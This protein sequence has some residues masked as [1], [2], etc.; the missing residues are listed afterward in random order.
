VGLK[1]VGIENPVINSP[2][3][4]P[5]RH[6]RFTDEGI[7]DQINEGRRVSSYFVPIPRPKKRSQ[8][9]SLETQWTENAPIVGELSYHTLDSLKT[10]RIQTVA[11]EVARVLLQKYFRDDAGQLK[12]FLFPQLVPIA[13]RWLDECLRCKDNAFPQ[14]LLMAQYA[15]NAADRIYRAVVQSTSG[16][17]RIKPILKPYD[18]LGSARYVDFDTTREVYSTRA[19]KC[20][21]NYVVVDTDSWEQKTAQALE[22]MDEVVC[23]VKNHNLGFTIPYSVDGEE[24]SYI[25]DFIVR[26]DDGHGPEDPLNLIVEVTEAARRD[27]EAKVATARNLWVHAVNNH[28]GFGRWVRGGQ[29]PVGSGE[30]AS[31]YTG[32]FGGASMKTID[33][34]PCQAI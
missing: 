2:F 13:R 7:S 10:E 8:Q 26:L 22:G 14:L 23:Y 32:T 4:E 15:H 31:W 20:H 1:P 29:G 19:D 17:K 11:Y 27:K 6:F 24:R 5:T 16:E 18:T 21:L 12:I 28:G 9:M 34:V 30:H 25:P 3:A 33:P